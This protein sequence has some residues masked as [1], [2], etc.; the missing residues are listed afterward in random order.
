MYKPQHIAE[1]NPK[2]SPV[3]ECFVALGR[4]EQLQFSENDRIT[5]E[6]M[7]KDSHT[8]KIVKKENKKVSRLQTN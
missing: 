8:Y 6:S 1:S 5:T 7:G 4:K 2:M 3:I